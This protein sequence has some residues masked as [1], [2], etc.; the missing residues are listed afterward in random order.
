LSQTTNYPDDES[1][2]F[3]VSVPKSVEF[4]LNLRIPAWIQRATEVRVN[5]R[6]HDAPAERSTF[7][8]ISR[9]W[10]NND[11]VELRLP[12]GFRTEPIDDRNPLVAAVMQGSRMMTG[13]DIPETIGALPLSRA[14]RRVPYQTSDYEFPLDGRSP[15]LFRPYYA[16]RDE[17]TTTYFQ[18]AE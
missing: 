6:T 7:C 9:T 5:G 1:I 18:L 11:V 13:V 16:I 12:F 4:A 8:S 10:K 2:Q 17:S 15:L 14:F 3:R